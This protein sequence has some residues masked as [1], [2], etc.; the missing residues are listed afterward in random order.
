M[1]K[2]LLVCV[3]L[4][5][6]SLNLIKK[7]LDNILSQNVS[8]IHFVHAFELQI[9]TDAF[10]FTT[11]PTKEQYQSVEESVKKVLSDLVA[12]FK[13]KAPKIV[14]HTNC[15]MTS[16]PKEEIVEYAKNQSIDEMIVGTRGLHGLQ[17]LF[18]SSFAEHMVRHAPCTLKILRES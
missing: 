14:F 18:S 11:Y 9:Y 6:E 3:N 12:I 10:Y 15:L 1:M 17:G 8:E 13:A 16:T 4:K 7:N 5:E 2:K